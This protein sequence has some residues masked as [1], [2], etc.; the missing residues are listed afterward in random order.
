MIVDKLN[1]L[2]SKDNDIQLDVNA[3]CENE[4]NETESETKTAREEIDLNLLN[5]MPINELET[6][7]YFHRE[8]LIKSVEGRRIDLLT[9]TSFNGIRPETEY[10]FGDLFPDQNISRCHLFKEKKV[11]NESTKMILNVTI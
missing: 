9:I 5:S 11:R 10:R 3:N 8:L 6:E 1:G 7:V 2:Q 4:P